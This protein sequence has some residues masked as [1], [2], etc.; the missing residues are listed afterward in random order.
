[1]PARWGLAGEKSNAA[2]RAAM[3]YP[4]QFGRFA[5]ACYGMIHDVFFGTS[6]PGSC[7]QPAH[8]WFGLGAAAP[9]LTRRATLTPRLSPGSSPGL[10]HNR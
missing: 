10:S 9:C 1:M 3:R 8:A 5:G 6:F 4:L 2:C 7:W